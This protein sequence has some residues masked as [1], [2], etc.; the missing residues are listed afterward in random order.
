MK[1]R[2]FPLIWLS[3]LP[4]L[5]MTQVVLEDF[6]GGMK[7]PWNQAFGDSTLQVVANPALADSTLD[8]LLINESAEV[9]SYD[10]VE[11]KAYS[12]LIAVLDDTL[13]LSTMNKFTVQ[14]FASKAT[15][16]ILKLEG[17]GQAIEKKQNIAVTNRWI[18]YSFDFSAAANMTTL[19][20]II[21]FFDPGV[22]ESSDTYLFDNLTQLP[23]DECSGTT[24]DPEILDD[25][26]CQRNATYGIGFQNIKAVDNPF[27]EGINTSAKVGQYTDGA[28]EWDAL[29][30]DN[31]NAL[32]LAERN[33]IQVKL[34]STIAGVF[35]F[36]LEGGTSTAIEKD[37]MV[38][39]D[40]LNQW[41]QINMDFSDQAAA[42][43]QRIVFFL[44]A[45]VNVEA[46]DIY[47]L[48]DI[49]LVA[50][51]AAAALEDFEDGPRLSWSS[52]GTEDVFGTFNGAVANPDDAGLNTS[53]NVGSYTKG[54]SEFGG[55]QADLPLDFNLS[56]N[57]QLNMQVLAPEGATSV[58][59]KL[60]SP[61]QGLKE[62]DADV[63]ETGA[64]VDLSFNFVDF[65][66][67]TD[68][69][70][71]EIVFD[72]ALASSDTWYFDNI[73]QGESTVD[74]CA[75]V[76]PDPT[77]F[78]DFDCQRNIEIT[79]GSDALEVV[80]N[81]DASGINND[82]LD[83]VGKYTDPQDQ[84]SALVYNVGSAIDL[85]IYN[86]LEVKIWSPKAVPLLFKLEGGTAS[87]VEIWSAVET[88]N[89]WVKYSIDFSGATGTD[90]TRLAIFFN[91]G[92]DPEA[93][94]VYYIDDVVW[95]RQPITGCLANFET[96]DASPS[97]WSYF[98][99]GSLDGTAFTIVQNP[100]PDDVNPSD[101][102]GVAVEASD[103][104]P[105]AGMYTDFPALYTLPTDNM[106]I[107]AK[108]WMDHAATVVMKMEGAQNGA[109]SSGDTPAEYTTPNQWQELTWDFSANTTPGGLYGRITMIFDI[110]NVP[111]ENKTYF[112]DDIAIG[113]SDCGAVTS[114][115][116]YDL[117]PIQIAPNP[118]RNS[119]LISNTNEA[120][121]F[122]IHNLLGQ[123]LRV[124]Q[125]NSPYELS[126]DVTDLRA[127]VYVL[128]AYDK[129]GRL[130]GNAKFVK[131]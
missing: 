51:P 78:D 95:K 44:N 16:F 77:I 121:R 79:G 32:P 45:G 4:L 7:L 53:A 100:G 129:A 29:V 106:T 116:V 93:G 124:I 71:L 81:P 64:W 85:S 21:L 3:L 1:R 113:S 125:T 103:G 60:F 119:L 120:S 50:K 70:R 114:F 66:T 13:D 56:S 20:K 107:R 46:G 74:P 89:A 59:M 9:G 128:T 69:E 99:N 5:G 68:F 83:K 17:T 122:E 18:E 118:V 30:I 58:T 90:H 26:E 108:I 117:K 91:A 65:Q 28:G 102:V 115:R 8:P 48:D 87:A 22:A 127:G 38:T 84:W 80:V 110:N 61:S 42:N 73:T 14:V 19:T 57:P 54:S 2:L 123:T 40:E 23:A 31:G 35:K 67:I 94:D 36:K 62:V 76:V 88:T 41:I 126:V 109:M 86:Q 33:Q 12:L 63:S 37:Y 43:H 75:D 15:S 82:P 130:Q 104:Q 105:W 6:E 39:E 96:P 47:Y 24:P 101:S 52:L 55:L 97:V 131:E 10:K 34:Y 111:S 11:G 25:F 112:F 92:Q 98:G 49:K 27:S 72:K